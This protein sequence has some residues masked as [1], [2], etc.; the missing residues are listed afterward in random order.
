MGFTLGIL[1]APKQ[2]SRR[3]AQASETR[4]EFQH[5]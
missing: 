3:S 5:P 4:A 2:H 1:I